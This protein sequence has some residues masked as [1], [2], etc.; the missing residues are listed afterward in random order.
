MRQRQRQR[1]SRQKYQKRTQS[2][3]FSNI[4]DF[5]TLVEALLIN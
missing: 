3:D 2:E 4:Y 5:A 1:Q